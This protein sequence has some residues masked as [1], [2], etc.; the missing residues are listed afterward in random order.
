MSVHYKTIKKIMKKL[1]FTLLGASTIL[2]SAQI[3][4]VTNYENKENIVQNQNPEVISTTSVSETS[5]F[6]QTVG[7]EGQWTFEMDVNNNKITLKGGTI[8]NKD[9]SASEEIRMMVYLADQPFDLNN[10]QLIG[11]VYSYIDIDGLN[12]NDKKTGEVYSTLWANNNKPESGKKYYPY[13]LIGEQNP[14]TN[15][16]EVRDIKVFQNPIEVS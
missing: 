15:E 9:D 3:A 13:I 11:E 2:L 8:V 4:K 16:F 1:F 5:N 10:P 7:F 6:L 12:A 14:E